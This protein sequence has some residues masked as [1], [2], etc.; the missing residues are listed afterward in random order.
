M[1]MARPKNFMPVHGG[2]SIARS[3]SLLSRWAFLANRIFILDNAD[4]P[5]DEK[6]QGPRGK[7]VESGVYVDGLCHRR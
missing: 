3:C 5:E 6:R 2:C 7:T 1:G 4:T